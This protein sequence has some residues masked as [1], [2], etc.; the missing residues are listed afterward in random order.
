MNNLNLELAQKMNDCVASVVGANSAEGFVMA[1]RLAEATVALQELLTEEYM[2]PIMKLQG[3]R[4]GFKTDR[5]AEGGYGMLVV[6]KCLIEAVLIGVQPVGN[7]FNIIAGDAYI[8]KEGYGYLLRT[9]PGLSY[10]ITAELP[11]INADKTSAAVKMRV[12]YTHNGVTATEELDIPAKVYPKSSSPDY[13]IGKATRK[14]RHWLHTTITG[15]ETP[16][17]DIMD[18]SFETVKSTINEAEITL[19]E[20]QGLYTEKGESLSESDKKNA[21]RIISQQ[22]TKSYSKLKKQLLDN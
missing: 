6:K 13:V 11:R 14:A 17:G 8:T 15:S 1:Y 12:K 10:K 7:Q 22:E 2:L 3:T 21:M 4:L 19:E 5:D 18:A 20:L 16:E 9:M